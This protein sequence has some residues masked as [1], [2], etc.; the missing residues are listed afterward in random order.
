M[1]L[2]TRLDKRRKR[3]PPGEHDHFNRPNDEQADEQVQP[4]TGRAW[5]RRERPRDDAHC[6]VEK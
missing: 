4:G 2:G 1:Q 6:G 5:G 3:R